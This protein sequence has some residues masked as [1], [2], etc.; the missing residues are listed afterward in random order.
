MQQMRIGSQLKY[1]PVLEEALWGIVNG[2]HESLRPR[3]AF[4][5]N[6]VRKLLRSHVV[7]IV[8]V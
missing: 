1:V 6:A 8:A 5:L 4:G 2:K 7:S 3:V